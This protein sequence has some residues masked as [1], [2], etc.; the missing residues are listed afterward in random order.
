M[1]IEIFWFNLVQSI[2]E[3]SNDITIAWT[4]YYD[5][6]KDEIDYCINKLDLN[7]QFNKCLKKR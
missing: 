5:L 1:L 3:N 6:Y 2:E 4:K 7:Y